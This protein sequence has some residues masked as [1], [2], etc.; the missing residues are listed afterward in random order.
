MKTILA[1]M[2]LLRMAFLGI[3]GALVYHGT[4]LI[5]KPAG[6]IILGIYFILLGIPS[7]KLK[8]VNQND[9]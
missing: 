7:K 1:I 8:K 2:I 6:F 4:S 3:G 5:N 9:N